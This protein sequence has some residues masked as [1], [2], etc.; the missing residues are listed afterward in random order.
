[1]G[2]ADPFAE[3]HAQ[4]FELARV[5]DAVQFGVRH[6]LEGFADFCLVRSFHAQR[7]P[8][9]V[10]HDEEAVEEL[11]RVRPAPDRQEIDALDEKAGLPFAGAPDGLHQFLQPRN[12]AVVPDPQQRTRRDIANAGGFDDQAA[13]LAAGE[14]LVPVE[15]VVGDPAFL[16][17]AP[18]H[19]GR[20]PGAARERQRADADRTEPQG[21]LGLFPGRPGARFRRILDPFRRF[22]HRVATPADRLPRCLFM[23]EAESNAGR[24]CFRSKYFR[25]KLFGEQPGTS[26]PEP[27]AGRPGQC[28]PDNAAPRRRDSAS[29]HRR[30][31]RSI[32]PGVERRSASPSQQNSRALCSPTSSSNF[33]RP[34]CRSA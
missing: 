6:R 5:E 9:I 33:A 34:V 11:R 24:N 29:T 4:G 30:Q 26:R 14:L 32:V 28:G 2:V 17:R 21:T 15:H 12:V 31:G 1:M 18:R 19:H 8:D 20:H 22:P 13:G 10:G 23:S 27:P 7:R 16:V 25:N 3:A